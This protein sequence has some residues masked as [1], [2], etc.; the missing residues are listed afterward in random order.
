VVTQTYASQLV[1]VVVLK[2]PS[3]IEN[4]MLKMHLGWAQSLTS[5]ILANWQVVIRRIGVQ[6]QP[7]TS[8][9][10]LH[11]NQHLG[12]VMSTHHPSYMLCP[13]RHKATS[14]PQNNQ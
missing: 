6:G 9:V 13:P 3:L 11:F 1:I 14:Y 4:T 10:T 5:A 12:L 7:G 8:F 2:N